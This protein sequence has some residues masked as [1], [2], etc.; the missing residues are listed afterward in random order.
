MARK[1]IKI[2]WDENKKVELKFR[3]YIAS[4]GQY[5]GIGIQREL[6]SE[7]NSIVEEFYAEYDPTS[8][9][10]HTRRGFEKSGYEM[11][12]Y[13]WFKAPGGYKNPRR[14]T[15]DVGWT[16]DKMYDDY[17]YNPEESSY[18]DVEAKEAVLKSFI[19]GYHGDPRFGIN[20][21]SYP[22]L[23]YDYLDNVLMTQPT[24]DLLLME[25]VAK[26][27]MRGIF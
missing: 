4:I 5:L 16:T 21:S 8:Y 15:I 6:L 24:I 26:A 10:R 13:K 14:I 22:K 3:H 27:N 23:L 19:E 11:A 20:A 2:T 17:G 18:S 9:K 25:A 7:V 12:I 1:Q